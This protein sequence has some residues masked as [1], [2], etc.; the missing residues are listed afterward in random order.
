MKRKIYK[1]CQIREWAKAEE[2]GFYAGSKVDKS[3]GFIHFSTKEQLVTTA[4]KHFKGQK[5]LVLIEVDAQV[6]P[7]KWEISRG[8]DLFPHLYENWN[9]NGCEKTWQ[10]FL[11]DNNIPIIPI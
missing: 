9:L 4:K 8:G 11:D 5:N 1:I 6:L 10:L 7:V 3:D 2:K